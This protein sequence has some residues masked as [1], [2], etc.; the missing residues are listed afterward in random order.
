MDI[1]DQDRAIASKYVFMS[2]RADDLFEIPYLRAVG[3][4]GN[5]KTRLTQAVG[6][7]CSRP[8]FTIGITPA[9]LFR[10]NHSHKPTLI[11]D[12]FNVESKGD[13]TEAIIQV[14]NAGISRTNRVIRC[15]SDGS[16][17]APEGF[18]PF[19]PKIL[20]GLKGTDSQPFE[21][22]TYPIRMEQT[23]R[24]DITIQ[25]TREMLKEATIVRNK[26]TLWKLR[27]QGDDLAERLLVAE[28]ELKA[29][30]KIRSRYIQVS[31]PLYALI[32]DE[33]V[34][35]EFVRQLQSR[36]VEYSDDKK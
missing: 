1:S 9:V 16:N 3:D 25:L 21:S 4:S 13:D 17:F 24:N 15:S 35:S 28:T 31:I 34:K 6:L 20:A 32:N 33:K 11:I 7:L 10:I 5:G 19:G 36:T 18:D 30:G 26:L 14:L 27:T 22:R 29:A 23:K 8:I 12:E 2:Y